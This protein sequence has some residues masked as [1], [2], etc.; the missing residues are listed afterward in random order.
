MMQDIMIPSVD[1][2]ILKLQH[3]DLIEALW[4]KP[5]DILW[6]LVEMLDY[7]LDTY[8]EWDEL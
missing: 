4:D 7:V 8:Y 5:D 6:G 2:D 1:L 3:Q